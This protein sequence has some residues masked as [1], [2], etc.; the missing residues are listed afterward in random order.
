MGGTTVEGLVKCGAFSLTD[1]T[2]SDPS[3]AVVEKF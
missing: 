2:V 3:T 1:I